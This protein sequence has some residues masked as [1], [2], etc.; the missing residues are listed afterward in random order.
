MAY[1]ESVERLELYGDH[2]RVR[3]GAVHADHLLGGTN[4]KLKS[5]GMPY[6]PE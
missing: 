6:R 4:L 5:L 2:T 3:L 1:H